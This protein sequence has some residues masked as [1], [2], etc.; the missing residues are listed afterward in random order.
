MVQPLTLIVTTPHSS[1]PLH[2]AEPRGFGR[3]VRLELC[4]WACGEHWGLRTALGGG[5]GGFE[6]DASLQQQHV[7]ATGF[8]V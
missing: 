5:A 3:F 8:L 6:A 1:L 7:R 2:R 4:Y